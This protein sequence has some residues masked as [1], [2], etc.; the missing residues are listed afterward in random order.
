MRR[1]PR[2]APAPRPGPGWTGGSPSS[3]PQPKAFSGLQFFFLASNLVWL[4]MVV[5]GDCREEWQMTRPRTRALTQRIATPT[6]QAIA[7]DQ[8]RA[9]SATPCT[10]AQTRTGSCP[11][12]SARP[13]P[14]AWMSSSV[15]YYDL[16]RKE[17]KE[18]DTGESFC[19]SSSGWVSSWTDPG[20]GSGPGHLR[21]PSKGLSGPPVLLR[22]GLPSEGRGGGW[23]RRGAVASGPASLRWSAEPAAGF[24]SLSLSGASPAEVDPDTS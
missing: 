18:V 7:R 9:P 23:M 12:A 20:P 16:G 6:M 21:A 8:A 13:F 5:V 3:A 22:L 10:P 19:F 14:F 17:G 11:G 1:R 4:E 2:P 24:L 15:Q